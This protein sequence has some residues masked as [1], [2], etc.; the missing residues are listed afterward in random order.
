[1]QEKLRELY[2]NNVETIDTISELVRAVRI[3]N[4]HRLILEIPTVT[5]ALNQSVKGLLDC[6]IPLR[7]AG[8]PWDTKYFSE[9]LNGIAQAQTAEDYILMGDLYELQMLPCLY[10]MQNAIRGTG[11]SLLREEWYRENL[12][13]LKVQD[14][15]LAEALETVSKTLKVE[16]EPK[17]Y[18]LEPTTSGSFT[19]GLQMEN[20]IRY[21]H[22]NRNPIEEA[23][24]FAER[25]YRVEQEHYLVIGFG[26]GYHIREL[27]RL[28]P[29]IDIVVVEPDPAVIYYAL[30]CSD[31]RE[32]LRKIRILWKPDWEPEAAGLLSKGYELVLF[33]PALFHI[34]PVRIRE[35]L[36]HLA[37]RKDSIA[38]HERIF[39]Q[40]A[41]E[42]FQNCD[43]YIDSLE[44][45][46]K[47]K[48]IVIVAGG[49]SLDKN[50][51][52][53]REKPKDVVILA[54][55]TVFQ[56]LVK[57]GIPVDYA[58]FSD[59]FIYPQIQG[60]EAWKIPILLLA[61][62][63]RRVSRYY[64]GPKYLICQQGCQMAASYAEKNGWR[65]YDSGGS[66]STLALD[67]AIRMEAASI[68]FIGLDL[69]YYGT[70]AHASGT[71]Q[72]TFPGFEHR[73]VEGVDKT[74]LNTSQAF[75]LYREWMERRIQNED[76]TMEV[77]D[78]TEGGARKKGFLVMTLADYLKKEPGKQ[79]S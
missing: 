57:K 28:Y 49:P 6:S 4:V 38:D 61:T 65:K 3:Q 75:N 26:M 59:A 74:M 18:S 45:T 73:K 35:Q 22:S 12:R 77:V 37:N 44:D 2:W 40:N 36:I 33:R 78:A 72:E 64:Q 71:L 20:G 46:I 11:V 7:E 69:A 19:L 16:Q 25:V 50:L 29:E 17:G 13:V 39:Y 67:I 15:S 14:P 42:N 47:G 60:A 41:R 9:V 63:D 23:R 31:Y 51:E 21:L 70:K 1:M 24:L 5:K 32:L 10:D 30:S 68:A 54:V 55:G 76:C 79:Y 66:V 58:V 34:E 43:A 53:L 62:A 48:R 27:V 56:L 52:Q 8:L